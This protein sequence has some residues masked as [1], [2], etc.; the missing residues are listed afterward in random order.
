MFNQ[1]IELVITTLVL[2]YGNK[3]NISYTFETLVNNGVFLDDKN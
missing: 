3:E 2:K 1:E